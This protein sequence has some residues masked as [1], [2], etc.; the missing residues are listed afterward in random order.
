MNFLEKLDFLMNKYQLNKHTF[1]QAS[2]IPYTTID[3]IYKKGYEGIRLSTIK[4][5]S[6]YF[7]TTI[8]Y[9]INDEITD[10]NY[11]KTFG[12]EIS[13]AELE[14]LEKYRKLSPHAQET[15]RMLMDR[16]IGA[17]NTE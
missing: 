4:K 2:G 8:D 1:S 3:G 6:E 9:L 13:S 17:Q 10:P 14:L 12:V 11:D 7:N 16:E 5:I 15:I